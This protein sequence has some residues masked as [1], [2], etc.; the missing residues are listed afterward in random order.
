M[1]TYNIEVDHTNIKAQIKDWERAVD[2]VISHLMELQQSGV[3]ESAENFDA[4][5]KLEKVSHEMMAIN[6]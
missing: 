5:E 3:C 6:I 2:S 4:I 1:N